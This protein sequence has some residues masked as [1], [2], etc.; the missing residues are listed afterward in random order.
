LA[1]RWLFITRRQSVRNPRR[2]VNES[3]APLQVEQKN[4]RGL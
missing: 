3:V 2:M 4:T 1:A